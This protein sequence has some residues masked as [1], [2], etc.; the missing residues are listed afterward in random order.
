VKIAQMAAAGLLA[1]GGVAA[2]AGPATAAPVSQYRVCV[3]NTACLLPSG[4]YVQGAVDWGANLNTFRAVNSAYLS[5]TVTFDQ[6]TGDRLTSRQTVA[7]P[8][9]RTV[10][11]SGTVAAATDA[12]GVSICP[13]TSVGVCPSVRVPRP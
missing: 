3:P 6:Y 13:I 5:V 2:A 8:Q 11:G 4:A 10:S 9:G 1:L 12:L 7:V